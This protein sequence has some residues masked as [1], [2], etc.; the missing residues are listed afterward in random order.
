MKSIKKSPFKLL[1]LDIS[2]FIANTSITR[3]QK[4]V[5]KPPASYDA[6]KRK[7]LLPKVGRQ[8]L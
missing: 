5:Q 1:R 8:L 3:A 7:N 2:V 4:C 6:N